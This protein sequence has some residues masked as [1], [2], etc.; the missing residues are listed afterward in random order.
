MCKFSSLCMYMK[1][2]SLYTL[3]CWFWIFCCD[4]KSSSFDVDNNHDH[5][6]Y[7]RLILG[8]IHGYNFSIKF[9]ISFLRFRQFRLISS[10]LEKSLFSSSVAFCGVIG[11]GQSYTH[12]R[13]ICSHNKLN[14]RNISMCCLMLQ[15]PKF[16]ELGLAQFL[17][18]IWCNRIALRQS[19]TRPEGISALLG[20]QT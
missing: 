4:E 8:S 7:L 19:T 11:I 16:S 17:I 14:H 10:P 20:L 2:S 12:S 3:S 5:I 15:V 18:E 13:I 9:N 6:S 1:I